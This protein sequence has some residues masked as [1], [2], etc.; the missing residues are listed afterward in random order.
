MRQHRASLMNPPKTVDEYLA[1]LEEQG[2]SRFSQAMVHHAA[3]L[4]SCHQLGW[5][6]ADHM[7]PVGVAVPAG[8]PDTWSPA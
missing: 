7:G 2:L 1:T 5:Q 6:I 8:R 3:E 4:C